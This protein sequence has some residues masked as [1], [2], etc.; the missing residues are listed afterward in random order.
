MIIFNRNPRVSCSSLPALDLD[1]WKE[2][3]DCEVK[4]KNIT[5]GSA[6]RV[7]PCVMCTCTKEGVSNEFNDEIAKQSKAIKILIFSLYAKV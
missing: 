7:S 2:R 5:V 1:L 4:G 6:Q 3:V